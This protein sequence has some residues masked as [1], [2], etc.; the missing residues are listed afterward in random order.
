MT[1]SQLIT[2]LEKAE[3]LL[4]QF[5]GGYSGEFLSAEEFHKAFLNDLELLKTGRLET[6]D[7]F[8]FWLLST[9][10]WDDFTDSDGLALGDEIY[11]DL[12]EYRKK[13]PF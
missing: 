11:S 1:L 4:S 10:C 2:N 5:R 9:S 13:H 8:Y 12:L 6:L 7:E 3:K